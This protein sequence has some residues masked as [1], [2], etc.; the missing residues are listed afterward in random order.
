MSAGQA[1]LQDEPSS[2]SVSAGAG[3]R[4]S[5]PA[6]AAWPSVSRSRNLLHT[7]WPSTSAEVLVSLDCAIRR[8]LAM[9]SA[10][11]QFLLSLLSL[12]T[13]MISL[14]CQL[15][16]TPR[17]P[18]SGVSSGAQGQASLQF[19]SGL[20]TSV[21]QYLSVCPPS[22]AMSP[23]SDREGREGTWEELKSEVLLGF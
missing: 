20:S 9:I 3:S 17:P 1:Q 13:L 14:R 16:A 5:R 15:L 21:F 11:P 22:L 18:S 7:S 4:T 8:A 2:C 12:T 6:S 23:S 10:K 19:L